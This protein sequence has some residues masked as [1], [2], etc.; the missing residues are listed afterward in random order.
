M[1][2]KHLIAVFFHQFIALRRFQV[3]AHHLAHQFLKRHLRL[4]TELEFCLVRVAEQRFD[5]SGAVVTSV[6]S[7]HHRSGCGTPHSSRVIVRVDRRYYRPAEVDT[8]LGDPTKAKL[9][10][11][12]EPKVTFPELVSEMV[13]ADLEAARRDELVKKHGYQ[14]FDYHE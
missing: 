4:P 10:L 6:D 14:A 9:K 8:L 7:H 2:I 1:I 5:F 13:R 12:W 11:G 3:V